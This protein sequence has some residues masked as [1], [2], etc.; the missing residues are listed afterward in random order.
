MLQPVGLGEL[1]PLHF[2]GPGGERPGLLSDKLG[3]LLWRGFLVLLQDL[4]S[5]SQGVEEILELLGGHVL[6]G[7]GDVAPVLV[8]PQLGGEGAH[9]V[10]LGL[11]RVTRGLGVPVEGASEPSA[12]SRPPARCCACRPGGCRGAG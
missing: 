10:G 4:R 1:R 9:P 8:L 11:W 5:G 6:E 3:P 12:V 2:G 7:I